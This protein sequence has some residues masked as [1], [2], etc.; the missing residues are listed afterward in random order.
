MTSPLTTKGDLWGFSTVDARLPVGADG[1]I[2]QADSA[3]ALGIGYSTRNFD[4]GGF[5]ATNYADAVSRTDLVTLQQL[6]NQQTFKEPAQAATTAGLAAYTYNNVA[7]PPSGIGATITLT[8]AAVLVVGGYT[9]ALNDRVFIK[10]EVPKEHVLQIRPK[11][12]RGF[13]DKR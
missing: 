6:Q 13:P 4:G 11:R 10:N 1:K 9:P 8:V 2:P 3:W 5:R 12:F 7:T